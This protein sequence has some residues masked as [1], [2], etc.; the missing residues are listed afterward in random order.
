MAANLSFSQNGYPRWTVC[1]NDTVVA[2]TESQLD[3]I[4]ILKVD[5][6]AC[7]DAMWE[8]SVVIDSLENAMN[9]YRDVVRLNKQISIQKDYLIQ[10]QEQ[11][12]IQEK[13]ENKFLR[14][15]T[16]GSIAINV[17]LLLILL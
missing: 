16:T 8:S 9:N 3:K 14:K 1:D 6:D 7:Y 13:K 12:V 11:V 17:I 4:N 5:R 15:I 2:I 10:Q